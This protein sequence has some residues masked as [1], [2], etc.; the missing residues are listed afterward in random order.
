MITEKLLQ[1]IWQF[2]YFNQKNLSTIEGEHIQIISR[3]TLNKNQGPDFL[4]AKII[5]EKTTWVGNIELHIQ[6]SQWNTHKHQIDK[7]YENV[8][9]HVVWQHD[10]TLQNV[11]IPIF[12]LQHVVSKL[13]L[14]NYQELMNKKTFV[15]CENKLPVLSEI[16]WVSWKERLAI[17]RLQ[18]KSTLILNELNKTQLDWENIF[19]IFLCKSF[20]GTVN[21]EAFYQ[22][23]KSLPQNIL[24]KQKNSLLQIE[25]LIFGQA[26]LLNSKTNDEYFLQLV[27]E[28]K[29]L[30]KKY[31]LTAIKIPIHFMRM[32]PNN[33]PTIRLA[34]LANL[35]TISSHLFSK[36]RE[37]NSLE[38]VKNLF[39]VG[40]G[41]YWLTHY[42][43]NNV[44][45]TS[46][47]N[48]G[49]ST[50]QTIIINTV[51]P[52]LFSY[53]YT[54]QNQEIKDKALH[55]LQQ[56]SAEKNAII[57]QWNSLKIKS[58]NALESQALLEL[59]NEYCNQ[60]KCLQCAV[61]LQLLKTTS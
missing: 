28:Y 9:L 47:K 29:H 1:F 2:G 52:T 4:N 48:L 55:W 30:Q 36:I 57:K 53:G 43:F 20:G 21:A 32:R 44:A 22:I 16:G 3:G 40:V 13:W 50:V 12:E 27:K 56:L 8:I 59:T 5:I 37:A 23:A 24:A 18:R 15:F 49:I 34:Q 45:A 39:K 38:Q 6:T 11:K 42:Q 14:N 25:A 46:A 17:E 54:I 26:G 58:K 19:W 60:K 31:S 35:I 51:I 33:F 61:G 10:T 41:K 7:N